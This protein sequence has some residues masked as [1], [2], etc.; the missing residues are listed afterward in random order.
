M[1]E[2]LYFLYTKVLMLF[3]S[4]GISYWYKP[5]N[6]SIIFLLI[7]LFFFRNNLNNLDDSKLISPSDG[8]IVSVNENNIDVYLSP[9]DRH[10]MIAP[11]DCEIRQIIKFK[12]LDSDSERLRHVF[13]NEEIG[14]FW[15]DQIVSKP[16]HWGFIPSLFY[17]RCISFM[18]EGDKLKQGERYGMIR[19]GSNML[20]TF[21]KDIME[22]LNLYNGQY[23]KLG[24]NIL[25]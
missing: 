25:K 1:K 24:Q 10:F 12:L 22:Q 13:Y 4:S 14:E 17:E 15:L 3:F 5:N 6:Y 16:L 9:L 7:L 23:I 8:K 11:C 2:R 20:W 18:K 21:E 19:F